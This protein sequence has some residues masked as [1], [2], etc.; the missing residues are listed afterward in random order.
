MFAGRYG[1]TGQGSVSGAM[2]SLVSYL[3]LFTCGDTGTRLFVQINRRRGGA[4]VKPAGE[5]RAV[6]ITG[7]GREDGAAP[8]SVVGVVKDGMRPSSAPIDRR[9]SMASHPLRLDVIGLLAPLSLAFDRHFL[10]S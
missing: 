9:E 2:Q 6:Y 1:A 3:G 4:L 5:V 8:P 10:H 7:C